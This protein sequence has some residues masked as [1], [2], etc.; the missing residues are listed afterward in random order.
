MIDARLCEVGDLVEAYLFHGSDGAEM[1]LL[2]HPSSKTTFAPPVLTA[3]V[4]AKVLQ[5]EGKTI[6]VLAEGKLVEGSCTDVSDQLEQLIS[7]FATEL[8]PSVLAEKVT[9]SEQAIE[10]LEKEGAKIRRQLAA[11]LATKLSAEQSAEVHLKEAE[12][13]AA[14]L[15]AAGNELEQL[16]AAA[17]DDQ[18]R[19]ALLNEN[20]ASLRSQLVSLEELLSASEARDAVAAVE[21]RSLGARLNTALAQLASEQ[22]ARAEVEAENAKLKRS[23]E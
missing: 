11:A 2:G 18:R 8:A 7:M 15:A 20:I 4:G 17:G 1:Q 21:I 3:V 6:R 19:M 10:T 16:R 23:S 9:Q 12:Q 22:K 5:F 14:L 13:R